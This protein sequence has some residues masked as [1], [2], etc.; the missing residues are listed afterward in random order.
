VAGGAEAGAPAAVPDGAVGADD[1]NG[2]G[3]PRPPGGAAG[4]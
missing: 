1:A 4:P 3:S 2:N